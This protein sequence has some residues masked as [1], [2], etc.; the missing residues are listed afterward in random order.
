[1]EGFCALRAKTYSYLMDDDSEVKKSK[2]TKQCVI[3]RELMFKSY[4]DCLLND[5]TIVKLQQRFKND[6]HKVY[7]EEVNETALSNNDDKTLQTHD[8]IK[9]YLYG[10]NT[11]KVCDTEML[12][13]KRF[14]F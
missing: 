1:M 8:N 12:N 7:T 4:T 9:T 13:D 5:K 10:T 6:H 3:K 2:R 14:I 11:F